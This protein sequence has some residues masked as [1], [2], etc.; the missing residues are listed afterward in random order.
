VWFVWKRKEVSLCIFSK[1]FIVAETKNHRLVGGSFITEKIIFGHP[2]CGAFRDVQKMF[3][4]KIKKACDLDIPSIGRGW[5][6]ELKKGGCHMFEKLKKFLGLGLKEAKDLVEKAGTPDAVIKEAAPKDEAEEIKEKA[7]EE[8]KSLR[9]KEIVEVREEINKMRKE[10]IKEVTTPKYEAKVLEDRLIRKEEHLDKKDENLDRT[11]EKVENEKIEIEKTK[12]ET[13]EYKGGDNMYT[14]RI[15]S[16]TKKPK[17]K[18]RKNMKKQQKKQINKKQLIKFANKVGEFNLERLKKLLEQDLK[19][20][21][22]RRIMAVIEKLI[23]ETDKLLKQ[24]IKTLGMKKGKPTP[25]RPSKAINWELINERLEQFVGAFIGQSTDNVDYFEKWN[26]TD[27]FMDIDITMFSNKNNGGDAWMKPF[28]LAYRD[29]SLKHVFIIGGDS[30]SLSFNNFIAPMFENTNATVTGNKV[31]VDL[32]EIKF[33]FDKGK[34]MSRNWAEVIDESGVKTIDPNKAPTSRKEYQDYEAVQARMAEIGLA[35]HTS[36]TII[37]NLKDFLE[38]K[39]SVDYNNST[40]LRGLTYVLNLLEAQKILDKKG[41]Q[42]SSVLKVAGDVLKDKDLHQVFA[43]ID[44]MAKGGDLV[45][46]VVNVLIQTLGVRTSKGLAPLNQVIKHVAKKPAISHY[47][48]NTSLIE[49]EV[50]KEEM[51]TD[52]EDAML[53]TAQPQEE[54]KE[55]QVD[56][57]GDFIFG[58]LD[59]ANP[60]YSQKQFPTIIIDDSMAGYVKGYEVRKVDFVEK[61]DAVL[62]GDIGKY[63]FIAMDENGRFLKEDGKNRVF[64]V[65]GFLDGN[66]KVKV[67]KTPFVGVQYYAVF[68]AN[69]Q[70]VLDHDTGRR[71][72][73]EDAKKYI[74]NSNYV[75]KGE[76][77][78]KGFANVRL[79]KTA[80]MYAIGDKID[81][82]KFDVGQVFYKQL[83]LTDLKSR[84]DV[85]LEDLKQMFFKVRNSAGQ[86]TDIY[87]KKEYV[88]DYRYFADR[89]GLERH[90]ISYDF[91]SKNNYFSVASPAADN[92]YTAIASRLY[93][94]RTDLN[95]PKRKSSTGVQFGSGIRINKLADEYKLDTVYGKKEYGE[96][97]AFVAHVEKQDGDTNPVGNP[98]LI[99]R[100][101]EE[102]VN[103]QDNSVLDKYGV[104]KIFFDNSLTK[105]IS[106]AE[107]KA[108]WAYI[109]E[110]DRM[111]RINFVL[112]NDSRSGTE[113]IQL[114]GTERMAKVM[115][116]QPKSGKFDAVFF[117]ADMNPVVVEGRQMEG[118]VTLSSVEI[119][120]T[121]DRNTDKRNT[122][123]GS[124]QQRSWVPSTKINFDKMV[125]T[126][127]HH[128]V[129]KAY[130][131]NIQ[132]LISINSNMVFDKKY[133]QLQQAYKAKLSGKLSAEQYKDYVKKFVNVPSVKLNINSKE[134]VF[135]ETLEDAET[136]VDELGR[137]RF[138]GYKMYFHKV[139]ES[140]NSS[141]YLVKPLALIQT[142]ATRML[143][144]DFEAIDLVGDVKEIIEAMQELYGSAM[145]TRIPVLSGMGACVGSHLNNQDGVYLTGEDFVRLITEFKPTHSKGGRTHMKNL[146]ETFD[147]DVTKASEEFLKTN[148]VVVW[149]SRDP[150]L[151]LTK[152]VKVLGINDTIYGIGLTTSLALRLGWDFDGDIGKLK[153]IEINRK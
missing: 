76:T 39:H 118:I 7:N 117:D 3:N 93:N 69:K 139:V 116:H 150:D 52:E 63:A 114:N 152:E 59:Q 60:Y 13:Q 15:I 4:R 105:S 109:P 43:T 82:R 131:W 29:A 103:A 98:V 83:K 70:P 124:I 100:Y 25:K 26:K 127:W 132:S 140:Y 58:E 75:R 34:K 21:K 88:A 27:D 128:I 121:M 38:K 120:I 125:E 142:M 141:F 102:L 92:D 8:A 42:G 57:N 11:K 74:T 137:I 20:I 84:Y 104:L 80:K 130:A 23:K 44:R 78:I 10:F 48:I 2:Y 5:S 113:S 135:V 126:Y 24:G 73:V 148:D 101:T 53:A 85:E 54:L 129:R 87:N 37:G 51:L 16:E 134:H 71:V 64:C 65:G 138:F 56:A 133:E 72:A 19:Q 1:H 50:V 91:S 33:I 67:S 9:K 149:A 62:G 45:A 28:E 151:G 115:K 99:N 14:I 119:D 35:I 66:T 90:T 6:L 123:V 112:P 36:R 143:K 32:G 96:N 94:V 49:K 110:V 146:L 86:A 95:S 40:S 122:K 41:E 97:Y 17:N 22:N 31:V 12:T 147:G 77:V 79:S 68:D 111:V 107:T 136:L 145:T 108:E 61:A 46:K 55:I 89:L 47:K 81:T 106:N 18:R 30:V 144:G 153:L